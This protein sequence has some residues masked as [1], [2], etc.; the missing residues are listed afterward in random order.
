MAAAR[1]VS[2]LLPLALLALPP[3]ASN[4][5]YPKEIE[6]SLRLV[7]AVATGAT[8]ALCVTSHYGRLRAPLHVGR[9][10]A[11]RARA[12]L[13]AEL[14]AQLGLDNAEV[15]TAVSKGLV[16]GL[17]PSERAVG[18]RALALRSS[19]EVSGAVAWRR[20]AL[21]EPEPVPPPPLGKPPDTEYPWYVSAYESETL[22]SSKFMA[23]SPD[24]VMQGWWTFPYYSCE[25]K[26]WL[27]SYTVPVPTVRDLKGVVNLDIDISNLEIN[28]CEPD[29]LTENDNQIYSFYGT[30]KCPN[31]T[32]YC[33]Y[34]PNREMSAWSPGWA[35]GSYVCRCRAGHYSTHHPDGF[36]GSLVEIAYQEYEENGLEQWSGPFE[37]QQCAPGCDTCRGPEP[38]LATYNWSFRISL[39]VI[40]VSCAVLTVLLAAY[41]R[42]H[43]R[44]K[45]FRVASPVFLTI[46]LLGCAIMYME[47]AAIFP[48]LDRY[49]CIAT[50]WTRHMGFCITYTALLM[51][52]W[53]VSLTYRVK[54]A[55]KLKLT[56]KQLLQ[57]MA[58]ILLIMLVYLCTWTLSAPPSAEDITDNKGL[59]FKQCTYNWWDHSLAIGEILFLLWGVRVCYRV[60][61][62]ESLYNEARLISIAIYNIFTVNSLMIAFH[63]LILPQAGPDIKYLLGFIRTQLSTSTTVLL[64]FLPK[65][66]RVLRGT[67]D[68]W[69]SGARARGA[70]SSLNGIGLVPDEPADLYQENEE[71]K[72]E[73]Q[74]LAAQIEFMK[75][76]QMEMHNRHLRPRPGSYF[77][78]QSPLMPANTQETTEWSGP[79]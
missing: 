41:T 57:W 24:A 54:S 69:D 42:R 35:R 73:V 56:D 6:S 71:L 2:L 38:C 20:R 53:R 45:V 55:H 14:L 58:P 43:R 7:H 12:D 74:K 19:G 8:G 25:A 62:A 23:S 51:K 63:L 72:E 68:T 9:W 27:L 78:A 40:S 48:V 61:H 37:C 5:T 39:L 64:V 66:L 3:A 18:A 15:L 33:D 28:Q 21:G 1:R 65:V 29:P 36:N 76:V 75:I 17:S 22:R 16:M 50:K 47:M 49:S 46:T 26:R 70:A 13:A 59:K 44:V 34:S 67:G 77:A 60:R 32:T 11:A 79:V 4:T 52:T 31:E 30:H 10:D